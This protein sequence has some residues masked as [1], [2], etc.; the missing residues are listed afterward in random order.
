MARYCPGN[1]EPLA[2]WNQ[3]P[4]YLT[5]ILTGVLVIGLVLSAIFSVSRSGGGQWLIF[6]MPLEP[7]WSVWRAFT[8]VLVDQISFFTPF[9][10][11][12]FYW[13]SLGL[14]THLGQ[15]KLSQLLGALVLS[16]PAVCVAW[17]LL[18]APSYAVGSYAF[19]GGLLVAFATL[20][21]NTEAWG[22]IPFKW[23]AFA[24]LACGS[25][26]LLGQRDWLQ[27]TQLWAA[28][29]VGFSFMHLMK[30][31]EYDDSPPLFA[32]FKKL[33]ERK[34]KF[35]VLPSP[36]AKSRALDDLDDVEAIDPLLDKIAR[37]GIASLTARE[38]A[39]LER[40]RAALIKK[41]QS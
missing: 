39:R 25:L 24:C 35:R 41:D 30:Q 17:W 3:H 2:R 36:V 10:I 5:T 27:L 33:F 8:Y 13:W 31:R 12:C 32:G 19:T 18:G 16:G 20:Y 37:T 29:A 28:C 26:M 38:R 21:P 7:A 6:T 23:L 14:E 40:A 4:I 15:E 9:A 1:N 34:P 11:L 22:W